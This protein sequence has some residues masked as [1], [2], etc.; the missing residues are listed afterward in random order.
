MALNT[1][2]EITDDTHKYAIRKLVRGDDGM[3]KVVYVDAA[4]GEELQTLEGYIVYSPHE[5]QQAGITDATTTDEKDDNEETTA[6]KIKHDVISPDGGD[7]DS[8][9][10]T[11]GGEGSGLGF[12]DR[13]PGNN[14]G[15]IDTPGWMGLASLLPVV[16]TP[17]KWADRAAGASNTVATNKARESMGLDSLGI[18]RSLGN[19]LGF[20]DESTIANVNIGENPYSVGFEALNAKGQ[21]TLTPEEARRRAATAGETIEELNR[22]QTREFEAKS[23]ADLDEMGYNNGFLSGV[24]NLVSGVRNVF[25][26]MLGGR[27]ID[28][29][30]FPDAPGGYS[31]ET[32]FTDDPFGAG[33]AGGDSSSNTNSNSSS[34]STSDDSGL[35][36][37][38][39]W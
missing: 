7:S 12:L 19:I 13:S 23:R 14:Y 29:S 30:T 34:N 2:G 36:G 15:Y 4:T 39:G 32:T 37:W 24:G 17:L 25:S 6:E 31:G 27:N 26:N 35:G 3:M 8:P 28:S 21:T 20:R 22:E 9:N 33:I 38:D 10:Q 11:V 18:G 5:A 16:G 1:T